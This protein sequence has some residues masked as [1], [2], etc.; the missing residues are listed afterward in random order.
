MDEL[1]FILIPVKLIPKKKLSKE[2]RLNLSIAGKGKMAGE[3]HWNYG[4]KTPDEV[5]KKISKATKGKNN[6]MYGKH[7][8]EE[9]KQKMREIAIKRP[10]FSKEH[11][12]KMSEA[13]KGRI[14]SDE[15]RRR[16]SESAKG[17][18]LSE[19]TKRKIG[20]ASKGRKHSEES[21]LKMSHKGKDNPMYGKKHSEKTL[22]NMSEIKKGIKNPMYGRFRE[23]NSAWRGGRSFEPYSPEFNDNLKRQI[24]ERDGHT[25][26]YCG[27]FGKYV[28]HIDHNKK[29]SI[30]SNLITL[31]LPHNTKAEY[32]PILWECLFHTILSYKETKDLSP[33]LDYSKC[34]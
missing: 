7:H 8:S 30:P 20:K 34:V 23:L 14:F 29:N 15:H 32:D 17:R 19:E 10:P 28:H 27:A 13:G 2:Q 25:C 9:A 11:R 5:K 33:K 31:C 24:R 6:P 4:K 22:H 18:I 3:K 1:N 21:R 16:I 26:Q 12:R